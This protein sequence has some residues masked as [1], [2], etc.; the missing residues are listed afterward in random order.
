MVHSFVKTGAVLVLASMVALS[1]PGMVLAS[2]D[3]NVDPIP[4]LSED[5]I[6]GADISSLPAE[7]ASGVVY[8]DFEGNEIRDIPGF[9]NLLADCGITHVRVRIWNDPF[10]GE[11][12]GYGGGNNDAETAVSIAEGCADA[13]LKMLLDFHGSDFWADPSKQQAPKAW[14]EFSVEEKASALADF[15]TETIT[16]VKETGAVVDMVQVGNETNGGFVG[17]TDPAAMCTLFQAGVDAVHEAGAKAVIHFTDPQKGTLMDWAGTLDS[18]GVDADILATSYYPAYHGSLEDLESQLS[19]VK[20]TYGK[21]VLVAESNYPYTT[22]DTDSGGE[23]VLE[24]EDLNWP[25]TPQGQATYLRELIAAANEAGALGFF[26]WEPAWITVGDMTGL[27]GEELE[28][29]LSANQ[30]IW[31]QYGSGWASSFASEYDPDDA[32][33][34]YGGSAADNVALFDAQG[35][36][37]PALRIWQYVRTGAHTD[38]VT[39]EG[40]EDVTV[41]AVVGED[42]SMPETVPVTYNNGVQEDPVTWN[43]EEVS[44]VDTSMAGTY[45]VTGT[46]TFG[47]S[48]SDGTTEAPVQATVNVQ[49]LN[50][51]PDAD[52]ASFEKPD[53]FLMEGEGLFDLPDGETPYEGESCLH[54]WHTDPQTSSVT[55]QGPVELSAGDYVATVMA[56]GMAGD[57]VTLEVL[58]TEG[59]VLSTGEPAVMADWQNWQQC[60]TPFSLEADTAVQLRIVIQMQAG[61]WGTCD[62]LGIAPAA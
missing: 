15:I 2:E 56:Q 33:V 14:E 61:G 32:G 44:A 39:V 3:V 43:E 7:L 9:C 47:Q 26:Y 12:N 22:V 55:Y 60:E 53:G 20:S 17:E 8:H 48:V 28:T 37:L 59:N 36:P 10:D 42:L 34:Y 23:T 62:C 35:N 38:T 21:D 45:T 46:V 52:A 18:Q 31:E 57:Q 30:Q 50:L 24:G 51:I 5:F 16:A 13:G 41:E 6:M 49:T 1:S 11:G 40:V 27:E 25:F 54:W 29:Q 58:D 4:D 19:E